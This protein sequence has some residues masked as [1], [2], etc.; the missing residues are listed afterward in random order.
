[1]THSHTPPKLR[2]PVWGQTAQWVADP[3]GWM[4]RKA[5]K[6]GDVFSARLANFPNMIFMHHP[7]AVREIFTGDPNIFDASGGNEIIRPFLGDQSLLLQ[8]GA[9][10]LRQRRLMMPPFHGKRMR[11][12]G[13]V[14]Q[15]A[16]RSA[17]LS[18]PTNQPFSAHS[19]L[20]DISL[21]VILR[22]VFGVEDE[23]KHET[24]R[25]AMLQI[26]RILNS[27]WAPF[28]PLLQKDLGPLTPW[29][30]FLNDRQHLKDMILVEVERRKRLDQRGDDIL[31]MLMDATDE[32]GQPMGD[33]ELYDQLLTLLGAGHET[34]ATSLS[35]VLAEITRTPGVMERAWDELAALGPNPAPDEIARLPWLDAI[36]REALRL[37]PVIPIVARQ[38]RADAVVQGWEIKEGEVV[39]PCIYLTHHRP[40]LYPEPDRF[41]P[42]RFLERKVSPY[43]W[44]PFGGGTRRCLGMAFALYEMKVVL[45]TLLQRFVLDPVGQKPKTVRRSIT[46][47]PRDGARIKVVGIRI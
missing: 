44:L 7:D 8:H 19:T 26:V 46:L 25:Q 29:K 24:W 47:A 22:A 36:C 13:S 4:R 18:W 30:Q 1:M 38:M 21:D 9:R 41:M 31:S 3:T 37:R 12:Y 20:Q 2:T 34:T 27:S 15:E 42:E 39:V 23:D 40:D 14:I 28:I 43:E 32:D 6:H 10:H 17:T 33:D 45:G 35:W 16:T 5:A 11:H